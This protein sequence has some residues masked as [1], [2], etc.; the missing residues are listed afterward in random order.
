MVYYSQQRELTHLQYKIWY[1]DEDSSNNDQDF[2]INATKLRLILQ[3][4][5]QSM[6]SFSDLCHSMQCPLLQIR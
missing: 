2:D 6:F 5:K 3:S 1:E 4:I